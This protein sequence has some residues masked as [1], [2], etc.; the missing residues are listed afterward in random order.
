M[1]GYGQGG[2]KSGL[3]PIYLG[4]DVTDEDGFRAINDYRNGLSIFVGEL[5][6]RSSV[7]YYLRSLQEVSIFLGNLIELA[8]DHC[9]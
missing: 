2:S 3:L 7:R 8:R 1:K 9:G 5:N 4:D 6:E